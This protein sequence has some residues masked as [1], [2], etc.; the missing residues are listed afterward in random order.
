MFI[1]H[2]RQTVVKTKHF[3]HKFK[4]RNLILNRKYKYSGFRWC[5]QCSKQNAYKK[6]KEKT[7]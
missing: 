6:A 7:N 4:C 2:C 3:L 1:I 5:G